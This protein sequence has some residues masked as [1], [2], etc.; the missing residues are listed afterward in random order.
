[1]MTVMIGLQ[2]HDGNSLFS[3]LMIIAMSIVLSNLLMTFAM[4][5]D[6]QGMM[7]AIPFPTYSIMMTVMIQ[8][9]SGMTILFPTYSTHDD[10]HTGE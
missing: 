9:S 4:I 5:E 10:C 2:A 6:C 3:L 7:K 1:M 8:D